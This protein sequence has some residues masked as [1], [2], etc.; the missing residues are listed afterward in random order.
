[1]RR[2]A[3][4]NEKGG[5]CK[6]TLAVNTAAFLAREKGLSVL[7][8][9]LDTQGH[10]G[11][12]LGIDVRTIRP[13]VFHL[14]ADPAVKLQDVVMPTG[15]PNLSLIPSHKEMSEL[16]TALAVDPRRMF[17]LADRL[18]ETQLASYDVVVFD[19]PP[20]MGLTTWN[21]L[22]AAWEVVVPVALTY[23]ALDG[24]A[25]MVDTI[26]KVA[27]EYQRADLRIS[28]VVPT[29]YRKTKLA[30]EILDKL[31]A[32]FPDAL[33]KTPLAY[34]VQIDEAQSH[35]KT[36]WEYAPSSRGARMLRSISEE[37]WGAGLAAEAPAAA[38]ELSA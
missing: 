33:A 24:C 1:M 22:I 8:V 34:N 16:A 25:E 5:T 27:D 35:G 32:Y 15:V 28:L 6:T 36:I 38:A 21:V 31:R 19:S 17:R 3:F 12:S 7:L 4:I 13:N 23:L 26:R 11:K 2:I 9:D 10:A 37:V 30:D 29:L 18:Q 20:S 14:L